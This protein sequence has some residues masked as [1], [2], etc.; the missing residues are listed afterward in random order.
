MVEALRREL[1]R[2]WLDCGLVLVACLACT[3]SPAWAQVPATAASKAAPARK[4]AAAR[5]VPAASAAVAMPAA[6][7][8]RSGEGWRV[9]PHPAWVQPVPG[10]PAEGTPWPA[11]KVAADGGRRDLLWDAQQRYGQGKPQF[12]FRQ[13]VLVT[14]SQALGQAS[15]WQVN[16]N[17]AFQAVVLHDAVI[18][19][20]CL[21]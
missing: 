20:H 9:G 7:A 10:E 14:Q 2:R 1:G 21:V 13:R 17:P 16:F 19:K 4:P 8:V 15:Q 6:P 11:P 5:P 12:H 3:G 18:G